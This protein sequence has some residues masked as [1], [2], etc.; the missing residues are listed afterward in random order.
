MHTCAGLRLDEGNREGEDMIIPKAD[1]LSWQV[2]IEW[3]LNKAAD[4]VVDLA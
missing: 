3:K 1:N 2:L 4:I